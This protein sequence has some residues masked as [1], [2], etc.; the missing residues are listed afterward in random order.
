ML[1]SSSKGVI[2]KF[3]LIEARFFPLKDTIKKSSSTKW[4]PYLRGQISFLRKS[5]F[6]KKKFFI[7]NIII[8]F[9]EA[10]SGR[11]LW[12]SKYMSTSEFVKMPFCK[13]INKLVGA[14]NYLPWKERTNLNLIENEVMDHVKGS[15]TKTTK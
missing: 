12:T 1:S 2:R 8:K 10:T 13:E 3:P 6:I 5:I 9:K 7:I 4:S 11:S 15:I 14:S